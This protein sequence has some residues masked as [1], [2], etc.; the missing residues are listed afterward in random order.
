MLE[1]T[2][3]LSPAIV[4]SPILEAGG[5]SIR[6]VTCIS[7]VDVEVERLV[8]RV[9]S[10]IHTFGEPQSLCR[11]VLTTEFDLRGPPLAM[12]SSACPACPPRIVRTTDSPNPFSSS[13]IIRHRLPISVSEGVCVSYGR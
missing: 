7:V 13:S 5:V 1:H 8:H 4:V 9:S 3:S 10:H 2:I 6:T 11:L 12:R